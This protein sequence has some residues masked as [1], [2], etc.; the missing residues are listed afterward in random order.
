MKAF[1]KSELEVLAHLRGIRKIKRNKRG[2]YN[3]KYY[4]AGR[5]LHFNGFI[6]TYYPFDGKTTVELSKVPFVA[7]QIKKY[8]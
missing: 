1:T 4:E 2:G 6:T 7:D 3:E 5:K 8:L